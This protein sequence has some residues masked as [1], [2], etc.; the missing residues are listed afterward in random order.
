MERAV[1]G[2]VAGRADE[3]DA[4]SDL[5][6]AF[7]LA[8][9]LPGRERRLDAARQALA[10]LGQ[11]VDHAGSVQNLYSTSEMTISAFG[12]TGLLVSF[13]ISPKM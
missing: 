8:H 10:R 13:S 5:G 4:G 11:P 2:R 7:H 1:A 12:N 9:V 6:L 3:A